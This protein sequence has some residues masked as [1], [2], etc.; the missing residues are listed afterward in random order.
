MITIK[1][2]IGFM[3]LVQSNAICPHCNYKFSFDEIDE[4]FSK[5]NNSYI[6]IKC[7]CKKYIGITIDIQGDFVAYN[8]NDK[9]ID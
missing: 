6:I 1:I 5:Q 7:K 4:K 2:P 8:L 9:I 3:K